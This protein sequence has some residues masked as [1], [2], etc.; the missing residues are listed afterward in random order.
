M[1]N[2]IGSCHCGAVRFAARV[3][4][5]AGASRCNCSI[6]V[7]TAVTG[8][9]VKPDA[10]ALIAGEDS[11][12]TYEWGHKISQR[13]FCKHC[14]VHVFARGHL[15]EL[16]GEY[17]SINYNCLEDVELANLK[18]GYWDGR[19]NNWYAGMRDRP[20]PIFATEPVAAEVAVAALAQ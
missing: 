20:W 5:D 16:G 17:V 15:A 11:L 18:V 10:F 14:G 19:H 3:D 8:G 2:V 12:A 1:D 4:L 6:C 9:I 13:F 7:R